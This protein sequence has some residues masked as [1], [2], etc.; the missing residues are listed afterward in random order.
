VKSVSVQ[1]TAI[2]L[3]LNRTSYGKDLPA[4]HLSM[5]CVHAN[6]VS[7]HMFWSPSDEIVFYIAGLCLVNLVYEEM[8]KECIIIFT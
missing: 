6:V 7:L 4:P 5:D 2:C 8:Y 3:T 1:S